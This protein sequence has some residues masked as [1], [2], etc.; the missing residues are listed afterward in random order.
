MNT[1][2]RR[3]TIGDYEYTYTHTADRMRSIKRHTPTG[4]LV[5]DA[6]QT[7]LTPTDSANALAKADA[8]FD[9]LLAEQD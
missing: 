2:T 9:R 6:R 7:F 5:I 4:T 1:I 8:L 3:I